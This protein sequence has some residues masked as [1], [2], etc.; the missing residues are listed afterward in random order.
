MDALT[1][2]LTGFHVPTGAIAFADPANLGDFLFFELIYNYLNYQI[3]TTG[4]DLMRRTM[5]WVSSIALVQTTLWVMLL[6]YRMT[7][8][9]LREPLAHVVERMARTAFIVTAATTMGIFGENLHEFLTV[10]VGKEINYL[11][12]GDYEESSKAIDQNLAYTQVALAAIDA[13]QIPQG[14][15]ENRVQKAHAMLFAGFGTASPPM[16][17]GVM[18]LLYQFTLAIFIGLAPPFIL[19]LIFDQTKDLFRR[20]LMYGIGTLFSMAALNMVSAMV[21]SLSLRVAGAM[22]GSKFVND[23]IYGSDPEGLSSQAL[24]QGGVGL[25]LTVLIISV[26]PLAAVFFQGTAG[27]FLSYSALD[28]KNRPGPQGQPVGSYTPPQ[29]SS[30]SERETG[31]RGFSHSPVSVNQMESKQADVIKR[32]AE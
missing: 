10:D 14:D 19:C 15:D 2:L 6:G 12:T 5:T 23:T 21:L 8:G 17:A 11:F 20:W 29:P 28:P 31:G 4:M 13:V 30:V 16:A 18:L 25:L 32:F 3:A 1:D 26:P 24:Q 7:T 22:W 9:Q 27:H